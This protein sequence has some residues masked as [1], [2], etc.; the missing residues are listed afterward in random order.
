MVEQQ[1]RFVSGAGYERAMAPWSRLAGEIFLEW[2][3]LP[4]QLSWI[5]VGCGNGALT[6]LLVDRCAPAEVIG[7]DLS[8]AQL[9][10]AR[11]RPS[12]RSVEFLPGDATALAFPA[13]RFDAAC[14]ALVIFFLADPA[15]GVAEMAR[16]V[17]PGG[18]VAAYAWDMFGGGFPLHPI[19]EEMRAMGM[20][21]MLPP[22]AAASR[23]EELRALWSGAGL[24]A[25][26]TRDIEIRRVFDDFEDFWSTSLLSASVGPAVA[27]MPPAVAA[28]LREGVRRRLAVDSAGRVVCL[29]R[30]NAAKG[31]VRA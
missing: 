9:A 23:I 11:A 24:E 27:A 12:T 1:I 21:P 26:E 29:A 17:R 30:A 18:T 20:T 4:T 28:Q 2:L 22:S 8:A 7:V 10:Y 25:V 16:V 6:E 14:M 3:A 19:Q 15:K 13:G 31:R 5:D